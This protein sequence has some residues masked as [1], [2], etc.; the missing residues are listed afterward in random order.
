MELLPLLDLD[1]ENHRGETPRS[2]LAEAGDQKLLAMVEHWEIGQKTDQGSIQ[3]I[4]RRI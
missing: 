1:E 2:M 4:R 3:G